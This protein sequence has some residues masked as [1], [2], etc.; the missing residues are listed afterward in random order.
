LERV[1]KDHSLLPSDKLV[2][3][4]GKGDKRAMRLEVDKF[5]EHV[6]PHTIKKVLSTHNPIELP[7]LGKPTPL[8]QRLTD[9]TQGITKI[10]QRN[11]AILAEGML[12]ATEK[13]GKGAKYYAIHVK[14]MPV[15]FHEPRGKAGVG[16]GYA[17]SATGPDHMEYPHDPF[18]ATEPGIALL[19]PLGIFEPV[20]VFDLGPQKL[21]FLFIFSNTGISSTLWESVCLQRSPSDLKPSMEL[22]IMSKLSQD[23][24]RVY[25]IFSRLRKGTPIWPGY[26]ISGRDLPP[27]TIRSPSVSL[28][29][30]NPPAEENSAAVIG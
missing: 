20:D 27:R 29:R 12:S 19:R 2:E 30:K 21:G 25:L 24:R 14:G 4:F 23:G 17:V 18:W 5:Y 6:L 11:E 16:L 7:S 10:R 1:L 26:S 3:A 8:E 28:M 15:P 13:I 22:W 9:L